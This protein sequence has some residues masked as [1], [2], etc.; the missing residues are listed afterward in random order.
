MEK[1]CPKCHKVHE[2]M[3]DKFCS[4]CGTKLKAREKRKTNTTRIKAQNSC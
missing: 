1:V 4:N 3:S 2:D